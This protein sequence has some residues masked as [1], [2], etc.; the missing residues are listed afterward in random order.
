[1][2]RR[3]TDHWIVLRL[4]MNLHRQSDRQS[5]RQMGVDGGMGTAID[6][7]HVVPTSVGDDK[8]CPMRDG[9]YVWLPQ[10]QRHDPDSWG[11]VEEKKR[12]S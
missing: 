1:M 2:R 10:R 7:T 6:N 5:D 9:Y 8:A 12:D 11:L 4:P 3:V